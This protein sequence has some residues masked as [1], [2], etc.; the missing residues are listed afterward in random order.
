V[1]AVFALIEGVLAVALDNT[2]NTL[3]PTGIHLITIHYPFAAFPLLFFTR[4]QRIQFTL[5]YPMIYS[6]TIHKNN[7]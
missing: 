1:I 2:K 7:V 5:E 3:F 4:F 6:N